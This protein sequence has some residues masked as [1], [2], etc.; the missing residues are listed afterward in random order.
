VTF[1]AVLF[2]T[3]KSGSVTKGKRNEVETAKTK[4]KQ[5]NNNNKTKPTAKKKIHTKGTLIFL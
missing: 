4:T 3:E 5:T 1:K 2:H